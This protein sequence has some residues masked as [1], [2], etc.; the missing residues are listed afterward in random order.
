MSRQQALEFGALYEATPAD[1]DEL[2]LAGAEQ[3]VHRAS[4][5]AE[6]PACIADRIAERVID[7]RGVSKFGGAGSL[8]AIGS[9][10]IVRH[11]GARLRFAPLS[12]AGGLLGAGLALYTG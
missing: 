11:T 3:L 2:Q 5:N 9:K 7:A 12:R 4:P 1:L 6:L 10:N 8:L